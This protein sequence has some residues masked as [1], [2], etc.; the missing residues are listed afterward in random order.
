MA[1][2]TR[3]HWGT[4]APPSATW[5]EEISCDIDSVF[6]T[7][8]SLGECVGVRAFRLVPTAL[9]QSYVL[10]SNVHL[11]RSITQYDAGGEEY[12][13]EMKLSNIPNTL[14]CEYGGMF[15][16][17]VFFPRLVERSGLYYKQFLR[18][19]VLKAFWARVVVPATR[20]TQSRA[21]LQ[22]LP[23][24]AGLFGHYHRNQSGHFVKKATGA[25]MGSATTLSREMREIIDE[26][27]SCR[28]FKDFFLHAYV[29]G[30]KDEFRTRIRRPGP[31]GG[32]ARW[33]GENPYSKLRNEHLRFS[34]SLSGADKVDYVDV[35]FEIVPPRGFVYLWDV[36]RLREYLGS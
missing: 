30:V 9:H 5:P 35:G 21:A 11:T 17:N 14:L 4:D 34:G 10:R 7:C 23:A 36:V 8:E 22:R 20:R 6:K 33:V 18:D 19:D 31:D 15:Y 28:A 25:D 32:S 12:Q 26:D 13:I 3:I 27:P 16:V 24:D 2:E 1:D 29:K